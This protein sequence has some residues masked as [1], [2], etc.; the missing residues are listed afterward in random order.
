[1]K[2]NFKYWLLIW[3]HLITGK[4]VIDFMGATYIVYGR[5]VRKVGDY[6]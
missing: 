4:R 2:K 3:T 6:K 5:V 1:M